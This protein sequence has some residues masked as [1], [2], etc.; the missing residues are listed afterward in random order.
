MLSDRIDTQKLRRDIVSTAMASR[1]LKDMLRRTWTAPMAD[2]QRQLARLARRMTELCILR[3]RMRGRWHVTTA[4]RDIR[5]SGAAWDREAHHAR[6]A[7]RV[8]RDYAIAESAVA[9]SLGAAP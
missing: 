1:A 6:I 3:A 7:E 9:P 2:E 4:P 8:A 5:D